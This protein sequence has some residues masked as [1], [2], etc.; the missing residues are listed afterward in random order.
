MPNEDCWSQMVV[1]WNAVNRKQKKYNGIVMFPSGHDITPSVLSPC[2]STI[3]HII[4]AGNRIL[5]VSKPHVECVKAICR[6]FEDSRKQILFRFTIG[7]DDDNVLGYWEANAPVFLERLESLNYAW[8]SG[9]ATSVS[10]EPMLDRPN[11]VRLVKL[12]S[13]F[14]TDSI[15]IGKMNQ[16]SKRVKVVTEEDRQQV[17]KIIRGQTNA[18]IKAVYEELKCRPEIRWKESIKQVVGLPLADKAGLDK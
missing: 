7:A 10:I 4:E 2:L 17:E 9:F 13:L 6:E 1:N 16:I 11:I 8:S 12:L 15:W 3:S 18:E 5:I 14:V